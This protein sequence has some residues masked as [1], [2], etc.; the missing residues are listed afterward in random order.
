MLFSKTRK[1]KTTIN[2]N[3]TITHLCNYT[4]LALMSVMTFFSSAVLSNTL[5][6][7]YLQPNLEARET[8]FLAEKALKKE[9]KK[10]FETLYKSLNGYSLQPYLQE[11]YLLKNINLS[12]TQLIDNF[13]TKYNGTPLDWPLRK[14]WLNYLD[15]NNQKALFLKFY[16]PTSNATLTCK[17]HMYQLASGVS[18]HLVL[19]KVTALWTV[20]KS[21][22]KAC[23]PLFKQWKDQGYRTDDIIW[24]RIKLAANGGK[25]TLLPYLIKQLSPELKSKAELWRSV[26]INPSYVA[27]LNRFKAKDLRETEI[28]TYALARYIWRDPSNAIKTFEKAKLQFPFSQKQLNYLHEKFAIALASKNHDEANVWLDKLNDDQYS[29]NIIQ[30]HITK[31]LRTGDW[32][33]INKALMAFP[34]SQQERVQWRY[35][36]GRSLIET[37]Q[38]TQGNAVLNSVADERHYYGFLAAGYLNKKVNLNHEPV[39]ISAKEMRSALRFDSAKRSIELF[40]IG[41]LLPARMEWNSWLAKLTDR[42]KLAAAKIAFDRGWF[43]R[44]I[45]TLAKVGFLNDT[46]LRFPLAFENDIITQAKHNTINPAWAF[47]ITRRESSFMNDAAS[48]VGA[49]GLMQLMPATAKQLFKKKISRKEL[50][51]PKQNIQLGTKYLKELLAQYDGNQILATAAYNAGPH[52]VKKWLKERPAL[53]ADIWIETIPFKETREYVKSVMAYQQIY[54]LKTNQTTPLFKQLS[55]MVIY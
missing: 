5:H 16:K 20:G 26:R 8:F 15:K 21:Q 49:S 18:K 6:E 50:Y 14:K 10:H 36:Y 45:F 1:C 27:S 30:W 41:R 19:P 9:D 44:A 28:V 43:D 47:A 38:I 12:N 51:K 2:R 42:E 39:N 40:D 3:R 55:K 35:W 11:A 52:R 34:K 4:G 46:D 13:L 22:P 53:S 31:L 23:D 54:L 24:Q 29:S 48:P 17:Y 37:N 25:V 7:E 33:K 32:P